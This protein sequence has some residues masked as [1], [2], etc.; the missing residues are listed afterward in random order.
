LPETRVNGNDRRQSDTKLPAKSTGE[1][2]PACPAEMEIGMKKQLPVWPLLKL[3]AKKP[4]S[5]LLRCRAWPHSRAPFPHDVLNNH[6]RNPPPSP[7]A[8]NK[9]QERDRVDGEAEPAIWQASVPV[10][11]HRDRD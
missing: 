3:T 2:P 5:F 11:K 10:Q 8:R 6:N 9:S 4:H 7:V 1:I